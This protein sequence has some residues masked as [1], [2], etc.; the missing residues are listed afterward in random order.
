MNPQFKD[1]LTLLQCCYALLRLNSPIKCQ[2]T[3]QISQSEN[4]QI[5]FVTKKQKNFTLFNSL[6]IEARSKLNND[7]VETRN[8]NTCTSS[9]KSSKITKKNC[10]RQ[11]IPILSELELKKFLTKRPKPSWGRRLEKL[12]Q[13]D[14]SYIIGWYPNLSKVYAS[15]NPNNN[16][17][18][19]CLHILPNDPI[20]LPKKIII[21]KAIFKKCADLTTKNNTQEEWIKSYKS[22]QRGIEEYFKRNNYQR[23]GRYTRKKLQFILKED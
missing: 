14:P 16:N 15:T 18:N 11:Q 5:R 13:F 6:C 12:N 3:I 21:D 20:D 9:S 22:A 8:T 10:Q 23:Q 7:E 19:T 1:P 2:T 4:D 17:N